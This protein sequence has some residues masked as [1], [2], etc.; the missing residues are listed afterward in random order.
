M[1]SNYETAEAVAAAYARRML[2]A[3]YA[4]EDIAAAFVVEGVAIGRVVNGDAE[5]ADRLETIVDYLDAA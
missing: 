4:P 1:T 3:S 5:T 2:R